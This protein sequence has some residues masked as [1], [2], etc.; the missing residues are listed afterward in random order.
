M[1]H[2]QPMTAEEL[3]VDAAMRRQ[4]RTHEQQDK[5][6]TLYRVALMRRDA[7]AVLLERTADLILGEK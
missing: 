5:A 2:T 6:L 3:R 4:S 1:R 7:R